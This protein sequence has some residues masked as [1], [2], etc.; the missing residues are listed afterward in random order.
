[1]CL[2]LYVCLCVRVHVPV[3]LI[4]FLLCVL[5]N[6]KACFNQ[7]KIFIFFLSFGISFILWSFLPQVRM[8]NRFVGEPLKL[9][10]EET[11]TLI[12][13][14][15][16]SLHSGRRIHIW[17]WRE[18]KGFVFLEF[19]DF[20]FTFSAYQSFFPILF[21]SNFISFANKKDKNNNN[22]ERKNREP[23]RP[24]CNSFYAKVKFI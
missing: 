1:M 19:G 22:N 6:G 13:I 21:L 23:K 5:V 10:N 7:R 11:L 18:K 3:C 24:T 14:F 4:S 9:I 2:C 15:V 16:L 8:Q 12:F 17:G 20:L